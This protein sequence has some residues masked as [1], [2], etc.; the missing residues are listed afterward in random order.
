MAPIHHHFELCGWSETRVV[1]VFSHYY[2]N[3]LSDRIYG[4]VGDGGKEDGWSYQEKKYWYLV[5]GS[6]GSAL[7]ILLGQTGGKGDS[8]MTAMTMLDKE[9]IQGKAW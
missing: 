9:T 2:G 1:A 4:N 6:A 5:P 3:P 8:C 7:Q